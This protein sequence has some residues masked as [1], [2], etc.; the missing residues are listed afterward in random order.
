MDPGLRELIE[1]EA[2]DE[3]EAIV[4][5]GPSAPPPPRMRIVARFG[6]VAT[7]R[8]P[9]GRIAAAWADDAVVSLKAAR[10]FGVDPDPLPVESEV[11]VTGHDPSDQRRPEGLPETGR[12]VLVGVIDWGFD[13]AHPNFRRADGSTRALAFWDQTADGPGP[14]PYGYGRVYSSAEIDSALRTDEPY[15]ALG[16]HP[17]TG[18]PTGRGS[19]GTHVLDIAAGNGRAAGA[20]I[21]VAPGADLLFIHLATRGTGGRANLG[22]SVT[23][24]EALDWITREAGER[25][26]VVNLSVGRHGGPHHGLTLVE[27]AIDWV[28]AERP[29]RAVVQSAGNYFEA[30]T[31]AAGT[32][33]PGQK[34]ALSWWTDEADLTPNELEVWYPGGDLFAVE[35]KPPDGGP[36]VRV[37]LGGEAA[38]QINGREVGRAYHRAKDPAA[39]DN[40]VN[41]FLYAGAPAGCWR[42]TLTGEDVV[43]GRWHAWVERDAGCPGCQ[44]RLDPEDADPK[45][46]TGTIANGFRAI[47]VGANSAHQPER[48]LASFSSCGPTRD[49]RVKPDLVA[50]GVRILAARSTSRELGAATPLV[51]RQ[52]GTSMAA[53][54]VTGAVALMFEAAGR[55]LTI[56]E[57]RRLLLSTAKPPSAGELAERWGSGILEIEAAVEAA[58]EV[59]TGRI[60][61]EE[62]EEKLAL[63][64]VL[65]RE[66]TEAP[67]GVFTAATADVPDVETWKDNALAPEALVDA[68]DHGRVRVTLEADDAAECGCGHMSSQ[69]LASWVLPE[70]AAAATVEPASESGSRNQPSWH[71]AVAHGT[72][73]NDSANGDD[74]LWSAGENASREEGRFVAEML[75]VAEEDAISGSSVLDSVLDRVGWTDG[76][77]RNNEVSPAALFDAVVFGRGRGRFQKAFEIIAMPGETPYATPCCGDLLVRRALGEG[78]LGHAAVLVDSEGHEVRAAELH[79]AEHYRSGTFARVIEGGPWPHR[80]AEGYK[81]LLFDANGRLPSDSVLLR[82][83]DSLRPNV[84]SSGGFEAP[85]VVGQTVIDVEIDPALREVWGFPPL[86]PIA[87][88]TPTVVPHSHVHRTCTDGKNW[89]PDAA[90]SLMSRDSMNPGFIKKDDLIQFDGKLDK[91]LIDLLVDDPD[92]KK[93]LAAQSIAKRWPSGT[94][95]LRVALVDLTGDK[96]C[97]PGYAGWGSTTRMMGTSAAKIAIAYAAHQLVFD[98]NQLAQTLRLATEADLRKKADDTWSAFTCPPDH[99]W[100]VTV[101]AST[102]PVTVEMSP[103]LK[104]HLDQMVIASFP[105]ISTPRA[106]D[107]ILRIGFEYLA[108]V[109]WQSGLRH[110]TRGGLWFP[111]TYQ[112]GKPSAPTRPACHTGSNPVRW[113]KNPVPEPGITITALS[114]A[115][116]MTL[117]AQ[118]RLINASHSVEI[119]SLLRQGCTWVGQAA[120]ATLRA[121]KCGIAAGHRHE[122]LLLEDVKVRYAFVYLTRNAKEWTEETHKRFATDIHQLVT[123]NNP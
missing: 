98:L 32:L 2:G 8:L 22:C 48:P 35:F 6:E 62:T 88:P 115:T 43:D 41:I 50:P 56:Q 16:Y 85:G 114:A 65:A 81:R 73:W 25:P 9:R 93:L 4:R 71:E 29:G 13:F 91:A 45:T 113:A 58:R 61:R 120:A 116:F 39:G 17:A 83:R 86:L 99:A 42:L 14:E 90:A 89:K 60:A 97:K 94:D 18:D 26:F 51:F 5:L 31:H 15:R 63:G 87:V 121:T 96:I 10:P 23:L 1:G 77:A 119:E 66:S 111:N 30:M 108:S 3:V 117:L 53:P 74:E 122:V 33:R 69:V 47:A 67:V 64:E 72:S 40:H 44:S 36:G 102:S 103:E 118:Q 75:D 27:Q 106:T 104:T 57:T 54:H 95:R 80:R 84:D 100:L 46:S 24:L 101:D 20:P 76:S 34:R 109:L 79:P 38:I 59:G 105:N 110:P 19:H 78:A 70:A 107:L 11:E 49:G 82:I 123:A 55:P 92:Y 7:C 21:G 68:A 52:S 112:S 28:L 37:P 12:G